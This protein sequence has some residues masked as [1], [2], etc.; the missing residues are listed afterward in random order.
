[1][2]SKEST[3]NRKRASG[4]NDNKSKKPKIPHWDQGKFSLMLKILYLNYIN[5]F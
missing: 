1:M 2:G 4:C 5:N 3:N